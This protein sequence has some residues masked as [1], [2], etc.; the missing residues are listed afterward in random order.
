MLVMSSLMSLP[1]ILSG[2]RFNFVSEG[3]QAV[4]GF[5]SLAFGLFLIWQYGFRDHLIY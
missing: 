3:L 4:T 2:K 5:L 1:F